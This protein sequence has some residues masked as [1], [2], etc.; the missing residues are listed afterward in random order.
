MPGSYGK[1][2]GGIGGNGGNVNITSSKGSIKLNSCTNISTN[3]YGLGKSAGNITLTA[4]KNIRV[5]NLDASGRLSANGGNITTLSKNLQ[6]G[7]GACNTD[8]V[9]MDTS[10]YLT[11]DRQ[12]YWEYVGPREGEGNEQSE[13]EGNWRWNPLGRYGGGSA[14]TIKIT[15]T[16]DRTFHIGGNRSVNGSTGLLLANG[17]NGG[18][19]DFQNSGGVYVSQR[20]ALYANGTDGEGGRIL[21]SSKPGQ[22][23]TAVI[24]GFVQATN[25]N[26]TS[27]RIGFHSGPNLDLNISGKGSLFAGEFVAVGNLNLETL[28]LAS[29][30]AGYLSPYP[31]ALLIVHGAFKC[32]AINCLPVAEVSALGVKVLENNNNNNRIFTTPSFFTGLPPTDLT[33]RSIPVQEH[34]QDSPRYLAQRPE[35]AGFKHWITSHDAGEPLGFLGDPSTMMLASP[36]SV[37][38]VTGNH[39]LTLKDGQLTVFAADVPVIINT[40]MGPVTVPPNSVASVNASRFG[41]VVIS[42]LSGKPASM[43]VNH[44]GQNAPL[45]IAMGQQ[46]TLSDNKVASLGTSDFIIPSNSQSGPVPGLLMNTNTNDVFNSAA[47][48]G[49]EGAE[50]N[51]MTPQML[52]AFHNL[53]NQLLN[54][55]GNG[56]PKAE[57]GVEITAPRAYRESNDSRYFVPVAMKDPIKLTSTAPQIHTSAS[58]NFVYKYLNGTK[59][60]AENERHISLKSGEILVNTIAPTTIQAGRCV[61]EAKKGSMLAISVKGDCVKV[62]NIFEPALSSVKLHVGGRNQTLFA[63]QEAVI[64]TSSSEVVREMHADLLGRRK[65]HSVDFEKE[66]FSM[67]TAE[68]SIGALMQTS[69]LLK[70]MYLSQDKIDKVL[71]GNMMKMHA[72]LHQVTAGHGIFQQVASNGKLY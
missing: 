52:G 28:D 11:L 4:A 6:A 2:G 33:R 40:N 17:L 72:C 16:S 60:K 49:L 36:G 67:T 63:G 35:E 64:A 38:A 46:I 55:T 7:C 24:D 27:G 8:S 45:Q 69:N 48:D 56:T 59:V 58:T 51:R 61:I 53:M 20:G 37:F 34:R 57:A 30:N 14:G 21:F 12:G 70:Q 1:E 44:G 71:V 50:K 19:I 26:N 68:Y 13:G 10:S 5:G 15:T 41:Q 9:T 22:K 31:F 39:T 42:S 23:L 54:N 25:K 66:H 62:R 47:G 29:Q 43:N 65:M 32:N 18:R 3:G